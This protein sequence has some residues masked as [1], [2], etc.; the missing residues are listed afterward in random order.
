MHGGTS[1]QVLLVVQCSWIVWHCSWC[2]FS[3]KFGN[4]RWSSQGAQIQRADILSG[5]GSGHKGEMSE[6][7]CCKDLIIQQQVILR[8]YTRLCCSSLI[9]FHMTD[10][11]HKDPKETCVSINAARILSSSRQVILTDYRLQTTD[12]VVHPWSFFIWLAQTQTGSYSS[13]G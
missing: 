12:Y 8:D 2:T 10:D 13:Q 5:T 4:S 3:C 7:Q 1:I 6:F 9:I 11:W